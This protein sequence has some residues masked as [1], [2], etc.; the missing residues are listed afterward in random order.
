[1]VC[2]KRERTATLRKLGV[3]NWQAQVRRKGRYLS[4][5]FRRHRDAEGW[6][7][8]MERRIDRGETPQAHSPAA[9]TTFGHLIDLH[10]SDMGEVGRAPRRSEAAVLKALKAD[11][12]RVRL[13]DLS[14]ERLIDYGMKRARDGAGPVTPS[15]DL[16][17]VRSIMVRAAAAHE[18]R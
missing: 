17:Y 5:T 14:R 3:G 6:A 7:L 10:L 16:G 15:I 4:E 18:L 8:E 2:T 12:G 1:M 11:L 9:P 13:K